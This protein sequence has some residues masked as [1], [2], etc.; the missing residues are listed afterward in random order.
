VLALLSEI[1]ASLKDLNLTFKDYAKRLAKLEKQKLGNESGPW[2]AGV[3][4]Q[5]KGNDGP[6]W[7]QSAYYNLVVSESSKSLTPKL[8]TQN[9]Q[10]P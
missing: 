3:Y 1:S 2:D 8:I 5:S 10:T 9:P 6:V 4:E 7:T